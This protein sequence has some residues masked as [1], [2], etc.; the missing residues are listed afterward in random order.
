MHK[1]ISKINEIIQMAWCD[2]TSFEDIQSLTGA[3]ETETNALMRRHLKPSSFRL[4]RTRVSGR[5][6]KH[7]KKRTF[8]NNVKVQDSCE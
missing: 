2:K 8:K 3:S 7:R 4:W 5:I 1:E 6:A